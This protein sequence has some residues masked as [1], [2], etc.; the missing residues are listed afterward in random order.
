MESSGWFECLLQQLGLD[1]WIGNGS[2]ESPEAGDEIRISVRPDAQLV[3]GLILEEAYFFHPVSGR[4]YSIVGDDEVGQIPRILVS[5]D[6]YLFLL[7]V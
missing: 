1:F 2:R 5:L 6:F 7:L 3:T 4:P